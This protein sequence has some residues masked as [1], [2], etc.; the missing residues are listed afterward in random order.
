MRADT[1]KLTSLFADPSGRTVLCGRLTAG[2]AG[3]N[4]EHG[5]S[6]LVFLVC[7][8]GSGLCDE[9]ISRSEEAYG[10]CVSSCV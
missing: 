10:V 1:T 2:I 8:V 7:Y 6:Y 9:L 4:L 3:S 5:C